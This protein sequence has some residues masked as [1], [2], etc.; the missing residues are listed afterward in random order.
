MKPFRKIWWRDR[1]QHKEKALMELGFIYFFCDPRSDYQ[2]LTDKDARKEAIKEGEGL[3][4]DWEPDDTVKEAM[5]FYESFKP[6]SALLLEDTRVAIDKVRKELRDLDLSAT[7]DK[8]RP[9]YTIDKVISAIKLV[10]PL[11][12]ELDEAERALAS[13]IRSTSKMRGQGEKTIFE[14]SLDI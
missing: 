10:P 1:S 5:E 13:E 9:K 11:V 12:K 7:D 14:D 4:K 2:Y 3:A 8:G 6:S